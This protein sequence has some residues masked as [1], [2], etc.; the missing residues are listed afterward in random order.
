MMIDL[1]LVTKQQMLATMAAQASASRAGLPQHRLKADLPHPHLYARQ[2]RLSTQMRAKNNKAR[3]RWHPRH[4]LHDEQTAVM[5]SP[6]CWDKEEPLPAWI[7]TLEEILSGFD[8]GPQPQDRS[9]LPEKPLPFEELL[10][11]FVL[12]ARQ[13]LALLAPQESTL[14]SPLALICLER[15]LLTD[16]SQLAE[17]ALHAEYC[18]FRAQQEQEQEQ[19][20]EQQKQTRHKENRQLKLYT[21][22]VELY[23]G[24]RLWQF[25]LQY[26]GLARLLVLHLEQWVENSWEFLYRLAV[27]YSDLAPFFQPDQ[28]IGLVKEMSPGDADRHHDG[29]IIWLLTFC[30]G[31]R[32]LY[33]PRCLDMDSDWL[34]CINTASFLPLFREI[35]ILSQVT[36]GWMAYVPFSTLPEGP[37]GTTLRSDDR[38]ARLS[39]LRTKEISTVLKKSMKQW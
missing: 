6:S 25:L 37:G 19:E 3:D 18:R 26:C 36:Y 35:H 20:Q 38:N 31:L 10:L 14:L 2:E 4:G 13:R 32:L 21:A 34:V 33:K 24:Q 11:P 29:S 12:F 9:L 28:D 8:A 22:F 5:F 30:S 16:L 1:D 39:A 7:E 15:W 27:D 17:Q 23:H